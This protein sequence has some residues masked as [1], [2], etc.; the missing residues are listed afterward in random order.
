MVVTPLRDEPMA[1]MKWPLTRIIEVHPGKDGKV[2]V[3]TVW[4]MKGIYQRPIVKVLPM[5]HQSWLK[6]FG[7]AG[8]MLVREKI[9]ERETNLLNTVI[10]DSLGAGVPCYIITQ[11]KSYPIDRL[12]QYVNGTCS[13]HSHFTSVQLSS[14]QFATIQHCTLQFSTVHFSWV[15]RLSTSV[16]LSLTQLNSKQLPVSLYD[17]YS[18]CHIVSVR[19]LVWSLQGH[20]TKYPLDKGRAGPQLL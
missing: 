14:F 6:L 1:P 2:R 20:R 3:V 7:F 15:L 9:G 16:Q 5:M 18:R 11:L 4:T 13:Y 10:W 19:V 12:G 8:S 17:C